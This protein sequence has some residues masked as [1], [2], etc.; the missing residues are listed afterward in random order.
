MRKMQKTY[1]SKRCLSDD[2]IRG[3]GQ[4]NFNDLTI[5]TA[6]LGPSS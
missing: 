5:S 6:V 2:R 3:L 1:T 4:R